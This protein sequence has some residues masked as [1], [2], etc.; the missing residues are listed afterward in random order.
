MFYSCLKGVGSPTRCPEGL[1]Y[2][3]KEGICVWARDSGRTGCGL[4]ADEGEKKRRKKK[5]QPSSD[6]KSPSDRDRP[7]T[8]ANGFSCPGGKLGVHISL[9]H[10]TSCRSYYV[11]LNGV[12]A[13][14]QGCSMGKVFNPDTSSC[15]EPKHVPGCENY[16]EKKFNTRVSLKQVWVGNISFALYFSSILYLRNPPGLRRSRGAAVET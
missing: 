6:V 5:K 12:E 13:S 8:L 11:C 1:H 2:S 14:E 4:P 10:P 7:R 9:P 3:D 15:D 16:Y